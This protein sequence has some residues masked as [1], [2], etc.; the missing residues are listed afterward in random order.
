MCVITTFK[1]VVGCVVSVLNL[2]VP[3]LAGVALTLFIWGAIRYIYTAGEEGHRQGKEMLTWGV[4]ALFVIASLFG[5][6]RLL[7]NTFFSGSNLGGSLD[8]SEIQNPGQW[9]HL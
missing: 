5:I 1:S 7:D 3:I 2:T 9:D 6:L 4:I 8:Y